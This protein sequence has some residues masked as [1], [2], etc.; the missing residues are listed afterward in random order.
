MKKI[1][2]IYILFLIIFLVLTSIQIYKPLMNEEVLF[3]YM[4][5]NTA[6]NFVP[7]LN[8]IGYGFER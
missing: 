5:K 8:E 3:A 1:Y 4:I 7:S 2:W 6:D